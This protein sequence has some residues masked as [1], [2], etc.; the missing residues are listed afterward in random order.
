ME[1]F[2]GLDIGTN[3]VGWAV[4][5]PEYKL[6]KKKGKDLWGIREFDAANTSA[7]RRSKR[8]NRRRLQREE[9]RIGLFKTFFADEIEKVDPLF[10]IRME[11]SKYYPE[12]KDK[13]LQSTS[14]IFSD[15]HYTDKEYYE[16]FPTIFHLRKA[17]I[18][19][20][21]PR[22]ER[23]GRLVY[24][25]C[26]NLFKHRGNFL[27]AGLSGEGEGITIASLLTELSVLLNDL[28]GCTLTVDA[29]EFETILSERSISKSEKASRLEELCNLDTTNK[30]EKQIL[31]AICGL[32]TDA[33]K[34]FDDLATEEKVEID[35]SSADFEDNADSLAE[36]VGQDNFELIEIMKALYDAGLLSNILKG[37]N[38]LSFACVSDYEKH[39]KD[40]KILKNLYLTYGT[41]NEYDSMFRMELPG[42]Y[43]AYVKSTNSEKYTKKDGKKS[44]AR[45]TV[46]GRKKD[47]LYKSISKFISSHKEA[48]TSYIQTEIANGT[49]LPKLRATDNGVIPNQVH[50][51]ELRVILKNAAKSLTFLNEKDDT[52]LTVADKIIQL[53]Q[54]R[55]PYYIGPVTENS[56]KNAGN[57]WVVRKEAGPVY[58]WNIEEKIDFDKTK[59]AF[60]KNLIRDCTYI[61]GEKVV[62]KGAL[63]YESYSVLNEINNIRIDGEKISVSLKQDIYN[64]LFK[65]GKRVTRKQLVKYLQGRGCLTSDGQL[66]GIDTNINNALT[67]YGRFRAIFPDIEKDACRRMCER[68]IELSTIFGESKKMLEE[69]ISKEFPCQVDDNQ[70]KRI[71]GLKFKDWG[72][73]S[74]ELL[75]LPGCNPETGEQ[76]SLIRALWETNYNFMELIH[77]DAFMFKESLES[78]KKAVVNSLYEFKAEDLKEFYFS[79][80]VRRMIWQTILIIKELEKVMGNAPSRIFIEMTRSE[81]EKKGD[82]GRKDSRA[83]QLQALYKEIKDSSKPWIAE[84][85]HAEENGSLRSKKL[86]LYY[87]QMGRCLYTGEAIDLDN[88]M[89]ANSDYDIDHIYPRHYVKDDNIL[90]NLVLVNKK[91]NAYKTDNYPLSQMKPEVYDLWRML[92]EKKLMNDEKYKRLTGKNPFTEEQLAGF[93][94]RQ[95]VETSQGTKGVADVLKMLLPQDKTTIVYAKASNVSD[96]RNQYSLYKS[97][98]IND[99]HH[100]NDAYL[101]IVVGNAYYTKFTQN[102]RNFILKEYARNKEKNHYN[103]GKMFDWDISR[104]GYV[105]W[106][107][108][109][110][111]DGGTIKLVKDILSKNTPMLSRQTFEAKGKFTDETVYSV[112]TDATG[113]IPLKTT[114]E[115]MTDICKYGGYKSVKGAY[116]FVVEHTV[117]GKR[118]RSI[119]VMPIYLCQKYREQSM[120]LSYCKKYLGLVDPRICY[121]KLNYQSLIRIDGYLYRLSGKADANRLLLRNEISLCLNSKWMNYIHFIEKYNKNKNLSEHI[122][123]QLNNELYCILLD[124]HKNEIYSRRFNAAGPILENGTKIFNQLSVEEQCEVL[125]EI[126]KL[127]AI[128]V[129][130]SDLSQIGGKTNTGLLRCSKIINNANEFL[131]IEQSVTGIYEKRIDLLKV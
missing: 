128:G 103:L 78:K 3:S 35:F 76:I 11:N 59:E 86:Y 68:I 106:K 8:A 43:S 95:L 108:P 126:L 122:S 123:E 66:T 34:I 88:L 116:F 113:Y 79:A 39:A 33:K 31:R 18:K 82:R 29:S 80:P 115:H 42:S 21:L 91:S 10:F 16:Q 77:A 130:R 36:S 87:L 48:D 41:D 104:D 127:S 6:I 109:S 67:S 5:N 56:A 1:Y 26:L 60:I 65:K 117:K 98:T 131:V 71:L 55:V 50:L 15:V 74:R 81:D 17:L 61:S 129:I 19:D 58:P 94:A 112:R 9:A 73:F 105:A 111:E 101:N 24:L 93:I 125:L 124:K 20:D 27:N 75:E 107:A 90:N 84:I 97:R 119:E 46:D 57:G 102:P 110:K 118:I 12:D 99:F 51:R 13:R 62:P 37:E 7:E 53:F 63:I 92:H 85:K 72:R 100:A 114:D 44:P 70:M 30:K 54:F 14:G 83:K 52:N 49:F 47:D 96:F 23:Y 25:A 38:Y 121:K 4:T 40:L 89:S 32:K 45:R 2:L 28:M 120:L 22:D 69:A 64:E